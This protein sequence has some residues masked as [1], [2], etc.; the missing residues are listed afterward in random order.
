MPLRY[1]RLQYLLQKNRVTYVSVGHRSTLKDYHDQLLTLQ[2]DA[3][4]SLEAL[5][6]PSRAGPNP[7]PVPV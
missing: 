6:V 4:W 5:P 3:T 1:I 2:K 7:Q